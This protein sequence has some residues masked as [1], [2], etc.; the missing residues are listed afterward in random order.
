M[1]TFE[2]A[3]HDMKP[4]IYPPP[5]SSSKEEDLVASLRNHIISLFKA[6]ED[7]DL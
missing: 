6:G 4:Y 3:V 1:V 2:K 7:G 5:K